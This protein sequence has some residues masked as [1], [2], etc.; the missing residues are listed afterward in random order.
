MSDEA[1]NAL[2]GYRDDDPALPVL[3][4]E[5]LDT[6]IKKWERAEKLETALRHLRACIVKGGVPRYTAVPGAALN[7]IIEEEVDPL[8]RG[9]A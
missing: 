2:R 7:S 5:H 9:D 3:T 8:L 1:I 6:I 4:I